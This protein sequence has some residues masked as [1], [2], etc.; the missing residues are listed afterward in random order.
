MVGLFLGALHLFLLLNA[1]IR[2]VADKWLIGGGAAA[3][4]IVL[5]MALSM[6]GARIRGG[7]EP[8]T[9][10]TVALYAGP[11]LT[12]A[13]LALAFLRKKKTSAGSESERNAQ[14][15]MRA[16]LAVTVIDVAYLVVNVVRM[17]GSH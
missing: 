4:R 15:V 16:W 13:V 3:V 1:A 11:A 9:G 10:A 6:A 2:S 7:A 14:I 12:A 8:T 5:L 17:S